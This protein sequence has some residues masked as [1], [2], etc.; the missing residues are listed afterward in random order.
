MKHAGWFVF[1]D[2]EALFVMPESQTLPANK[3][4]EK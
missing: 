2:S 4:E 3:K 1:L